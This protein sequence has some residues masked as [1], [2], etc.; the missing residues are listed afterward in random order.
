MQPR[1]TVEAA[2]RSA[3]TVA[4]FVTLDVRV[5]VTGPAGED[6]T[7]DW[8]VGDVGGQ[9]T[10]YNPQPGAPSPAYPTYTSASGV[11]VGW[12]RFVIPIG[13]RPYVTSPGGAPI[14]L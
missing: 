11:A 5:R 14:R 3:S 12:L 10:L 4:G 13:Y 8:Q 7:F 6:V 2:T 1:S 9:S